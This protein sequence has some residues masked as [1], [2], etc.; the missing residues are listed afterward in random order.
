MYVSLLWIIQS[1]IKFKI[2][3]LSHLYESSI[4]VLILKTIGC[5]TICLFVLNIYF[6]I[7]L[8]LIHILKC[9]KFTDGNQQVLIFSV[10]L[11]CFTTC[12]A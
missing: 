3:V 10:L 9:D 4:L 6:K 5:Y 1:M 12:F 7:S 11:I 2:K 8:T